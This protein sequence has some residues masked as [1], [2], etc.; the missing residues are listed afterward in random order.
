MIVTR[1]ETK[2][3]DDMIYA[4]AGSVGSIHKAGQMMSGIATVEP[5]MVRYCYIEINSM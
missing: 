2:N 4:R 3:I 1:P 5:N